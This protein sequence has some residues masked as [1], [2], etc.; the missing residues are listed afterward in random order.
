MVKKGLVDTKD[1]TQSAQKFVVKRKQFKFGM[2]R[3]CDMVDFTQVMHWA[4]RGLFS[5]A[6]ASKI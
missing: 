4:Y 2:K 3:V 1:L 5:L 6:I